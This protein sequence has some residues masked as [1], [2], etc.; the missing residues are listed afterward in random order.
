MQG[1]N[2][3]DRQ[4]N[5]KDFDASIGEPADYLNDEGVAI[6][7]AICQHLKDNKGLASIDKY[8]VSVVANSFWLYA[9]AA[10]KCKSEGYAQITQSGY[11]QV[12]AEYTV[13]KNEAANIMKYAEKY[14]LNQAAREKI[15]AFNK[16]SGD[17][18]P[19]ANL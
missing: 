7:Y 2:R 5:P 1:T 15:L 13:M 6:Y 11:S 8:E 18:N 16:P 9:D 14:G 19:F 3:A 10:R 17:S 4:N 12:R